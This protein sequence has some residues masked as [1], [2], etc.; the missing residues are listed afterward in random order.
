MP[1]YAALHCRNSIVVQG[2]PFRTPQD[3]D[4]IG[5]FESVGP[6][7]RA[8]DSYRVFSDGLGRLRADTWNDVPVERRAEMVG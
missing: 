8:L 3:V 4:R 6:A 7:L 2:R 5:S 1:M